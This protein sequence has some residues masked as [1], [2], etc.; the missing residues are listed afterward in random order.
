MKALTVTRQVYG[1]ARKI[2]KTHDVKSSSFLTDLSETTLRRIK[3]STSYK[4][5]K[6][7]MK[8]DNPR[9]TRKASPKPAKTLKTTSSTGQAHSSYRVKVSTSN[10]P[11]QPK[12]KSLK[13]RLFGKR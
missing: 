1:D 7:L 8:L 11:S 10:T 6:E 2:L 13:E 9:R 3:K 4:N 5:Y 12:K